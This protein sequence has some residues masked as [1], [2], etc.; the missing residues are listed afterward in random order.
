MVT[1][2]M[3]VAERHLIGEIWVSVNIVISSEIH[4][5]GIREL[6]IM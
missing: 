6:E 4:I 3:A 2:S 1:G 5:T